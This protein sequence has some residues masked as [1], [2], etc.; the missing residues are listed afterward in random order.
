MMFR[1]SLPALLALSVSLVL[2]AWGSAEPAPPPSQ[3]QT[4]TPTLK[5]LRIS[6]DPFLGIRTLRL[7]PGLAPGAHSE[8]EDELPTLTVFRP[9][10]PNG[11][12]I[13][14]A[15]GG[16]YLGLAAVPEGRMVA[17]WFAARGVT[18]FVLRY[19]VGAKAP[20]PLP[21]EDAERAMRLVRAHAAEFGIDPRR[22]G[23]AGFSAGG[24]LAAYTAVNASPPAPH[25]ADPLDRVS[26]RPDF[27]VLAYPWVNA[28]RQ[29]KDGSSAYCTSRGA[30]CV[31][32]N[33]VQYGP[34]PRIASD[35]P[36]T[37]IFHT[38][39]DTSVPVEDSVELFATLKRNKV[40][41]ELHIFENGAHGCSLAADDP[42]LS[43]WPDLLD[44]WLQSRAL[45]P[46]Q[47]P[48]G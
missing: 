45:L 7:W 26:S 20:L 37:F 47:H 1:N 29:R 18:A 41:V 22:I 5:E 11:T 35:F 25:A 23:M 46:R 40:P 42:A 27:L 31:A 2:P 33:Y 3:S 17:D 19:R 38:A 14:I 13:V 8:D 44:E 21:L 15:P 12:A 34:L 4:P 43:R 16:A 9:V 36:P 32:A 10:N 48:A 6:G 30:D 28:T 24:H 39:D